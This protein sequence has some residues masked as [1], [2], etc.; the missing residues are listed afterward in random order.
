MRF[1]NKLDHKCNYLFHIHT[2][3]F[4]FEWRLIQ[5]FGD[6]KERGEK[7]SVSSG[8]SADLGLIEHAMHMMPD[9]E[10]LRKWK[11]STVG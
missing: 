11:V 8:I 2:A 6:K 1:V 4:V 9:I 3:S 7:K 10:E 5:E